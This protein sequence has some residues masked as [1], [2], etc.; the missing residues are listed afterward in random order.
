MDNHVD[1][2]VGMCRQHQME[3]KAFTKPVQCDMSSQMMSLS[4]KNCC[5][6]VILGLTTSLNIASLEVLFS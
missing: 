1:K 2:V 4:F 3:A 5:G 6:V